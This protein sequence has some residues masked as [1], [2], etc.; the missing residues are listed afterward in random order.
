MSVQVDFAQWGLIALDPG[1]SSTWWFTWIFDGTH[2]SRMSAT[3]LPNSPPGGNVQI[4][5][6]WSS[7]GTLWVTFYNNGSETVTFAPTVIVAPSRY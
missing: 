2:W 7:P 3:P 6:E 1:G 5:A 4:T